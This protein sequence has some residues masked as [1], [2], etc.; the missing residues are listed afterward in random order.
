MKDFLKSLSK[1][2]KGN[3][4]GYENYHRVY[5]PEGQSPKFDPKEPLR[6]YVLFQHIQ[7]M[8]SG[9]IAVIAETGYSWF[10]CQKLKLPRK[11]R[12]EFQ[13]QYGSIGWL[14]GVTLGYVQATPKKRVMISCIGDG[15]FY[16]TLLDISIMILLIRNRQ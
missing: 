13:M 16:V 6:V 9:E 2:L 15:S 3:I 12:Y 4:A 11:C 5:V 14:V 10:N 7:K 8:L 1:R